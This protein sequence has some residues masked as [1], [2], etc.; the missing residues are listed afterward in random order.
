MLWESSINI[1][2]Y[3]VQKKLSVVSKAVIKPLK[4]ICLFLKWRNC[5]LT[6]EKILIFFV[7]FFP[8][9]FDLI[10]ATRRYII[11]RLSNENISFKGTKYS[12][13]IITQN[14][15]SLNYVSISRANESVHFS[16]LNHKIFCNK[17]SITNDNK[18]MVKKD[19]L[20]GRKNFNLIFLLITFLAVSCIYMVLLRDQ[21]FRPSSCLSNKA[22][23][24]FGCIASTQLRLQH[25]LLFYLWFAHS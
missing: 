25:C 6:Y 4:L 14:Y 12:S 21:Q 13:L 18:N 1:K 11:F 3:Y 17:K 23:K 9:K 10:I 15:C 7:F 16:T 24:F 2:L 8:S 19:L 5:S 20:K 22:C